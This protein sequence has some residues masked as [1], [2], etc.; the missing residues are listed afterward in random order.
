MATG[1]GLGIAMALPWA[2]YV[3]GAG[4]SQVGRKWVACCYCLSLLLRVIA[5]AYYLRLLQ[6]LIAIAYGFCYCLWDWCFFKLVRM[7][8]GMFRLGCFFSVFLVLI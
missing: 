4:T 8:F 5:I 6:L 3:W 7:L 1:W 2:D